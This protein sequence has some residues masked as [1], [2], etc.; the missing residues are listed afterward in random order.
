MSFIVDEK[1][2]QLVLTLLKV[3]SVKM[4]EKARLYACFH[5]Q[6]H[7]KCIRTTHFNAHKG[8]FALFA[9]LGSMNKIT[10]SLNRLR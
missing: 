6:M 9:C 2:P 4:R 7:L 5:L 1:L 3:Q 8:F 10:C